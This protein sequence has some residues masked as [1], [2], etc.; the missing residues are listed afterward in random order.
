MPPHSNRTVTKTDYLFLLFSASLSSRVRVTGVSLWNHG[1]YGRHFESHW[2]W[3]DP[4]VCLECQLFGGLRQLV[5]IFRVTLDHGAHL[6]QALVIWLYLKEE[7]KEARATE[8][9]KCFILERE[10]PCP[11]A[12][13]WLTWISGWE[14]GIPSLVSCCCILCLLCQPRIQP[15]PFYNHQWTTPPAS[16]DFCEDVFVLCAVP[17]SPTMGH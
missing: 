4:V 7:K 16:L 8:V 11:R 3:L 6:R 14:R 1:T 17:L 12:C 10:K 9:H 5:Q 13:R 2:S 15:R